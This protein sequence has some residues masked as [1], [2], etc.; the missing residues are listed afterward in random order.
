MLEFIKI[1]D[2]VKLVIEC[3]I[4]EGVDFCGHHQ[5][6]CRQEGAVVQS[7]D[8]IMAFSINGNHFPPEILQ[9]IKYLSFLAYDSGFSLADVVNSVEEGIMR[10][11][12]LGG[13]HDGDN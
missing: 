8:S 10:A 9:E 13:F 4:E 12:I 6:Y 5:V 11:I 7:P 3:G 1:E 2:I